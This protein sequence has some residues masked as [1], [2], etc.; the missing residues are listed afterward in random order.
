[1]RVLALAVLAMVLTAHHVHAAGAAVP[2]PGSLTMVSVDWWPSVRLAGGVAEGSNS[3][4]GLRTEC[5]CSPVPVRRQGH[6]AAR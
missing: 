1:M 4:S 2:E 5:S 6:D 3:G